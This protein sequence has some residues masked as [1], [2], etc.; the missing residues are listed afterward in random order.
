MDDWDRGSEVDRSLAMRMM[1]R[2]AL[3]SVSSLC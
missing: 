1:S 2:T 3:S